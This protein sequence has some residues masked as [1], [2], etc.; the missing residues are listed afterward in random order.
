[1]NQDE[2]KAQLLKLEDDV[3]YFE[4]IFSGK[5]SSKVHGLYKPEFRQILLHNKNFEE[6]TP[7]IYA[8]IHE[9]AHHLQFTKYTPPI[10]NRTHTSDFWNILHN[11]LKKAEELKIYTNPY[12]NDRDFSRLTKKI[13]KNFLSQNGTLMKELGKL[14][15]EAAEL[16]QKSQLSFDDYV[17]R[18][19]GIHRSTAKTIMKVSALDITPEIGFENMK[20]ASRVNDPEAREE[21][22]K[23]F[24][25]GASTDMVRSTLK[26]EPKQKSLKETLE[27]ERS[28]IEKQIERLNTRLTS[29]TQRLE[30]EE[31]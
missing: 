5:K 24:E 1:M 20:I 29:I 17:D 15:L 26:G 16:C 23:S 3:E 13:K 18:E 9:F 4:V 6:D 8:A 10:S 14:L 19:L 7:L 22:I 30:E 31:S 28:R 11:L 25:N 27:S 21:I 2:V 12:Q